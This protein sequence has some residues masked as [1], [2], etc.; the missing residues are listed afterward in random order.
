MIDLPSR[1]DLDLDLA[2]Y[3][4]LC[5]FGILVSV[6]ISGFIKWSCLRQGGLQC[7]LE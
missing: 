7:V 4:F 3:S 1:R 5:W 2:E 6:E